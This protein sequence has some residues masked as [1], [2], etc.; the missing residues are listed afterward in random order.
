MNVNKWIKDNCKD[1][2]GSLVAIT[3][4]SGDL[5][6]EVCRILAALNANLLLI[7]RN[8]AKTDKLIEELKEINPNISITTIIVNLENF[9]D[10]KDNM[11]AIC[12]YNVDYLILNAGAYKIL[13]CKTDIDY[14]NVFQIN[15][16][17]Q[18]YIVRKLI[19]YRKVKKVIA[20]DSIAYNYSKLNEN[21]I[22]FSNNNSCSK[23]Y[24]NSKRF[25]MS[26]LYELLNNH[27]YTKLAIVHPGISFTNITSH[28]PKLIFNIIKYPMKIIF[29]NPRKA[30][31]S[32]VDGI[33]K[34]C[35]YYEWIGPKCFDIWGYPNKKKINKIT[36][37]ESKKI[38]KISCDIYK[39]I[40][41]NN[42]Y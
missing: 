16:I 27:P 15:F 33:Y 38:Y 23:V 14:D 22:D 11:D 28:Y 12:S 35:Q 21:D 7:N 40:N 19:E 36:N 6:C 18:Y 31:L 37:E 13:R 8:K 9:K 10:L 39:E 34:D 26:S 3:G 30:S 24:G 25:L 20:V 4:A 32:I 17:S 2:N 41:V 42:E 29:P 1:L 5:G